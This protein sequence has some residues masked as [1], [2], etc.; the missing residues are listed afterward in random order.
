MDS[1]LRGAQRRS[2]PENVGAPRSPGLLR[3]ARNDDRGST[4]M[5]LALSRREVGVPTGKDISMDCGFRKRFADS[6]PLRTWRAIQSAGRSGFREA[7]ERNL[8]RAQ[9]FGWHG[10]GHDETRHGE[11]PGCRK[12]DGG[13]A[14]RRFEGVGQRDEAE[15]GG[16]S[17]GLDGPRG[18]PSGVIRVNYWA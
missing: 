16:G 17:A 13:N 4:Q 10:Q 8:Y 6:L 5:Q 9:P 1:S 7:P 18:D 11:A 14:Q 2:N 15:M 12:G 3:F